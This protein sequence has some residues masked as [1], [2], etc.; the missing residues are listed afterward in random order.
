V[1]RFKVK[2]VVALPV[3]DQPEP[4]AE[5]YVKAGKAMKPGQQAFLLVPV[6]IRPAAAPPAPANPRLTVTYSGAPTPRHHAAACRCGSF[7]A[8]EFLKYGGQIVSI[9]LP[10]DDPPEENADVRVSVEVG[11]AA[12]HATLETTFKL[13]PHF[14]LT[15]KGGGADFKVARNNGN[16]TAY[17]Q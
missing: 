11:D 7:G 8:R 4:N 17:L 10:I 5:D 16:L 2:I 15:R 6:Q 13:E 9:A 12:N 1:R 14:R 3:Y